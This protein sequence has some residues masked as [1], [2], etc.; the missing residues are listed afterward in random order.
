MLTFWDHKADILTKGD[1]LRDIHP[2]QERIFGAEHHLLIPTWIAMAR[3]YQGKGNLAEARKLL[4]RSLRIIENQPDCSYLVKTDV[5]SYMGQYY[6]SINEYTKAKVFF[7]R[8]LKIMDTVKCGNNERAA[9]ALNGLAIVYINQGEYPEAENSCQK[10][11]DILDRIFDKNHP[12]II[13]VQKTL[14]QLHR[15][16]GNTLELAKLQQRIDQIDKRKQAA[17]TSS[18][19]VE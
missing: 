1:K 14:I 11:L 5:L 15:Q 3:I 6:I 12:Q 17:Y 16:A 19:T 4:E 2:I 8:A 10:A 7:K 18:T 9:N 13:E